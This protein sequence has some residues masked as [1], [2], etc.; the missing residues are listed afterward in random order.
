M[1]TN[2][3]K[4][5]QVNVR[6]FNQL[7]T[8]KMELLPGEQIAH[9]IDSKSFGG[10][11][12]YPEYVVTNK[13]R[14]WT[15]N[16]NK[17]LTP[18]ISK[19]ID[20]NNAY[21]SLNPKEKGITKT[22]YIHCLVCNYFRNESDEIAIEFFGE[23]NV[24]AHHIISINIPKSLKGKG[25][26]AD[27][28][29]QCMKD[30]CKSNVVYQEKITDHKNDT[31]MANGGVTS[32]ERRG[33]AVWDDELK[34]TRTMMYRSG[35]LKGNAY[36]VY[37]VYS[38]DENGNLM[39]KITQ[40]LKVKGSPMPEYDVILGDYKVNADENTQF[41][42][43]NQDVILERIKQKPPKT[44]YYDRFFRLDGITVMYGLK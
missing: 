13:G 24:Q 41:I 3:L 44:Q 20:I 9:C 35:Q 17:W 36:G 8:Q 38:K 19:D 29:K 32:Q 39:K 7:N 27:K 40:T 14:V 11:L 37:Y 1:K 2:A 26:R 16:Q 21:W 5:H 18:Q 15:L 10:S 30:S 23:K 34:E 4:K 6:K 28:M 12:Y 25:K 31:S 33:S 22:V 43:D 42:L